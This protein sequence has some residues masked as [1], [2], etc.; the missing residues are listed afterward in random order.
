MIALAEISSL[1]Q[2]KAEFQM[3]TVVLVESLVGQV[4]TEHQ[5]RRRS[6]R[7]RVQRL[8]LC[9]WFMAAVGCF[10]YHSGSLSALEKECQRNPYTAVS[11]TALMKALLNLGVIDPA[12]R[13]A[14]SNYAQAVCAEVSGGD[15]KY[16]AACCRIALAKLENQK[17]QSTPL[18]AYATY[19]LGVAERG[20]TGSVMV[21][22]DL[23]RA[24][25]LTTTVLG[26]GNSMVAAAYRACAENYYRQTTNHDDS[27]K[28]E[29]MALRALAIDTASGDSSDMVL[30][31]Q[32]LLAKIYMQTGDK[33]AASAWSEVIR[34]S[35]SLRPNSIALAERLVEQGIYLVGNNRET[36]SLRSVEEALR[37]LGPG[38]FDHASWYGVPMLSLTDDLLELTKRYFDTS[39]VYR[40]G[41][42]APALHYG[43]EDRFLRRLSTS[44]ADAPFAT[45][46]RFADQYH[47]VQ[48]YAR[49]DQLYKGA[50][51][52]YLPKNSGDFSYQTSGFYVVC[53]AKAAANDLK[54]GATDEAAIIAQNCIKLMSPLSRWMVNTDY[55]EA[56]DQLI[57]AFAPIPVDQQ[58]PQI[59]RV[60]SDLTTLLQQNRLRR[61]TKPAEICLAEIAELQ[62]NLALAE[63]YY[64]QAMES[65]Q[66]SA[67][68]LAVLLNKRSR[69]EESGRLFLEFERIAKEEDS[70]SK[71]IPV[72]ALPGTY[73]SLG[74]LQRIMSSVPDISVFEH[75]SPWSEILQQIRKC[76]TSYEMGRQI[77]V[78][79]GG[80][81][82]HDCDITLSIGAKTSYLLRTARGD[83]SSLSEAKRKQAAA[84]FKWYQ[85]C[86][87]SSAA[88]G[89]EY[90]DLE[91][92]L[93]SKRISGMC[94]AP[95]CAADLVPRG[96]LVI[97]LTDKAYLEKLLGRKISTGQWP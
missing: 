22:Q 76:R 13:D 9:A 88:A 68:V 19:Q 44:R 29:E 7:G 83:L 46:V 26:G 24:I 78:L 70:A 14:L 25:K 42:A 85:E 75:F 69:Y 8:I 35:R 43:V 94:S 2:E 84:R 86:F 27:L 50:L 79:D 1:T 51:K 80:A 67:G 87:P 28:S 92:N 3:G 34:I 91:F 57:F 89:F 12:Y 95:Y 63:S 65:H 45:F 97:S 31:D 32:Q 4:R 58:S 41:A 62:G 73:V 23:L 11:L 60:L 5:S 61:I 82:V 6:I 77:N 18:Y 49:A 39:H 20:D 17:R 37:I 90:G 66:A 30:L 72:E 93:P 56:V 47:E 38:R 59:R 96:I 81:I 40:K 55:D 53:M 52:L 15:H 36:E 33:R 74:R 48:D 64:R 10:M 16:A 54:R 71:G 21:R